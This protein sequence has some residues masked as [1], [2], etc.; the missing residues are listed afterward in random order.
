MVTMIHKYPVPFDMKGGVIMP[1]NAQILCVQA[2]P[3]RETGEY[4][5]QIWIRFNPSTKDVITRMLQ[6]R[7]EGEEYDTR[8]SFE[9]YIGTIQVAD[10]DGGTEAYH[11]FDRGES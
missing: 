5:P 10:G 4:E 3:S 9:F 8:D 6:W 1:A 11:L 2:Q 7:A